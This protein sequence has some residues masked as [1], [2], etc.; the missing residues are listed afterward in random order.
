MGLKR[1]AGICCVLILVLPL[2]GQE[3]AEKVEKARK[4]LEVKDYRQAETVIREVLSTAPENSEANYVLGLSLLGQ[5]KFKEAEDAF[6]KAEKATP[7]TAR[8]GAD[9]SSSPGLGAIQI[10]LARAYIGQKQL[11]K[12]GAALAQAEKMKP[13]DPDVYYYRGMLDAHRQDY[14]A[15]ARDMD[16]VTELDPKRAYAYYYAGIAYNQIKKPDKMVERFQVFLKL[17][18]D[19]PEAAKVKALLRVIK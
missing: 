14:T 19:A 16:K 10:G 8:E 15:A 17:A 9:A 2:L 4:L 5:D 13:A 1:V 7:E 18:P 12:A 6:L 11:D 3:T